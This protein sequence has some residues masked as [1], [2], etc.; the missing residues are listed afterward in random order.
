[1]NKKKILQAIDKSVDH[2]ENDIVRFLRLG[3]EI[4]TMRDRN[5]WPSGEPL[6]I[7]GDHCPL[8]DLSNYNCVDCVYSCCGKKDPWSIFYHN[9]T[10]ENA[11]AVVESLKEL[12]I[13]HEED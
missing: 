5:S 6:N 10:L 4:K 12:K 9:P 3:I 11:E 8:C 2:W 7:F 13:W 1:M